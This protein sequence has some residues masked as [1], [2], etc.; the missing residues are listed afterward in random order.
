M[1]RS[2][3]EPEEEVVLAIGSFLLKLKGKS[4]QM[5]GSVTPDAP[6]RSPV[7]GM[8]K[9]ARL[10]PGVLTTGRAASDEAS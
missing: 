6:T 5:P 2:L 7:V 8:F 1:L 4:S 10:N 9:I 3:F